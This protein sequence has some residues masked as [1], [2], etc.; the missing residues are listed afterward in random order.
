MLPGEWAIA[1]GNPL[2]L[3]NTVKV[4]IVSAVGRPSSEVGVPQ[5]RVRFIQTDAAII[6]G[7]SGG[8]LLNA[9]GEANGINTAIRMNAEGLG[10]AI[11]IEIAA[12]IADQLV[13]HGSAAHPY[14]GV[15]MVTLTPGLTMELELSSGFELDLGVESGVAVVQVDDGSAAD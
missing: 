8:S 15:R 1:I 5:K 3:N 7:N 12:R 14:I 10:F 6:P 13:A 4:G 9:S 11:P 2:G